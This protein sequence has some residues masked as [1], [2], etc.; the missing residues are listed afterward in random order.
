LHFRPCILAAYLIKSAESKK[1]GHT[2]VQW[3][4]M[5]RG[6]ELW[7]KQRRGR[8]F[9]G[10]MRPFITPDREICYWPLVLWTGQ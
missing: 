4:E 7:P 3:L 1:S 2:F 8:Y 9:H 10:G 5:D 6:R